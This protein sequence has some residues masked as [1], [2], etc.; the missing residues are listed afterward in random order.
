M[1]KLCR[2]IKNIYNHFRRIF[3]Y[4]V[5]IGNYK[6]LADP[7]N[8]QPYIIKK[9]PEHGK[10]LIRLAKTIKEKYGSL[11]IFDIGANFGD[12]AAMLLSEDKEYN[13][14]CIEGDEK[15][16]AFLSTNFGR[17][18]NVKMEKTFLDDKEN[19]TSKELEKTGGSLRLKQSN[20]GTNKVKFVTLDHLIK[21]NPSYK[22]TKLIKIDTDGYDFKIIRG[23][24]QYIEEIKPIL[25]FEYDSVF[26]SDNKENGVDIFPFLNNLGYQT[27]AFYDNYGRF[28]IALTF[29]AIRQ[30]KQLDRY[31]QKRNGAFAYYDIVSFHKEDGEMAQSF[32]SEEEKL[33]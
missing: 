11:Q 30:I 32:I 15:P 4:Y 24:K 6:L 7:A 20:N 5:V 14:I 8:S 13:I 25:Y 2:L 21:T 31:I 22:K 9:Y 16:F 17:V 27:F 29:E 33:N 23:A 10:A 12:T 18:Q 28:L 1:K 26:L 19:I 3:K